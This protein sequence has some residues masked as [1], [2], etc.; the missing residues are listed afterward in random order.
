MYSCRCFLK[1]VAIEE[2]NFHANETLQVF[3]HDN[4]AWLGL[5]ACL[6]LTRFKGEW[7]WQNVLENGYGNV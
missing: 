3:W 7:A 5:L 2:N 6:R 4:C 1:L